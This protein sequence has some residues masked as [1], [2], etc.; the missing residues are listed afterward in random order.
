M[1]LGA[2]AALVKG[3][4]R[5]GPPRDLLAERAGGSVSFTWLGGDR[6]DGGS[7][8]GTGCALAA[9]VAAELAK[10][11]TIPAAIDVARRFV[12]DAIR[13]AEHIGRR[14]RFLVF[15]G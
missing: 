2:R 9:A 12:A 15:D 14:A 10:G 6:I 11:A 3:G 4:H 5:D 8:H 1:N 7:V 13:R